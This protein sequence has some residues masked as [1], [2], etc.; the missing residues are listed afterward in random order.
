MTEIARIQLKHGIGR[1]L[2]L[3][4]DNASE[5]SLALRTSFTEANFEIGSLT[6]MDLA[7]LTN[8]LLKALNIDAKVREVP[9]WKIEE[10]E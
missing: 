4:V 7:E 6:F 3:S 1:Q 9:Q 2:V 5:Y 10:T 8:I